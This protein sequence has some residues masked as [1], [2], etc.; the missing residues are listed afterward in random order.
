MHTER[1]VVI[2]GATGYLGRFLVEHYSRK[3][4]HVKA[5]VRSAERARQK[6]IQA[7]LIEAQVTQPDSL[8]GRFQGANLVISC[9]GITRQ[10]DGLRYRD[11]DYQANMNLLHEALAAKVPRFVYVHVLGA[12]KMRGVDL[13]EAKQAFVERLQ[14]AQIASTVIAPSGYFSDMN[15]FLDMARAGRVWLFGKGD[16]Q[17]NPIHG[18]DLADAVYSA[19]EQ[20]LAWLDVGGPEVFS[21]SELAQLAL[22]VAGK[23]ERITRLPDVLRRFVLFLLPKVTPQKLYGPVQFFMTAMGHNMV[24]KP[25]GRRRLEDYFSQ[26]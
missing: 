15:D 21:H 16:L 5:L 7:E 13:I 22:K 9:V 14:A 11:V 23:P 8:K 2:A 24:G 12:D 19:A 18:A 1:S 25:Y 6:G 4:W 17:L 26:E 3:G 10:K 20:Q